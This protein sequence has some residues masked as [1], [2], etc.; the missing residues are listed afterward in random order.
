MCSRVLAFQVNVF[1]GFLLGASGYAFFSSEAVAQSSTRSGYAQSE[2]NRLTSRNRSSF[3][4]VERLQQRNLAQAVPRVGIGGV[5]LRTFQGGSNLSSI[6]R[7][8]P[9]TSITRGPTVSPYL[10]LSNRF[11]TASDYQARI[12]PAREA[13]RLRQ[14]QQLHDIQ[15]QRRLNQLA[16]QAPFSITGDEEAAPTGHAAVFQRIE[17]SFLNTGGYYPPPS[18]PKG[19]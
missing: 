14:Q 11:A 3:Y 2:L 5:N 18:R 9:F 13:E 10:S 8:K 4:S 6:Q 17:G 12:R 7:K 15:N 16:A 19:R 1:L